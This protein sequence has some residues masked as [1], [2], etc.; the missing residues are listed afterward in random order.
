[1]DIH[2]RAKRW[3]FLVLAAVACAGCDEPVSDPM[4]RPVQAVKIGDVSQ[5]TGRPFPGKAKAVE[6]ANLSF[7]VSGPLIQLPAKVGAVVEK[8]DLL[9]QIDRRD[10]EVQL[11]AEKANLTRAQANLKAMESGD[12]PEEI[13]Q[14]KAQVEKITAAHTLADTEYARARKLLPSG[15]LSQSEHDKWQE[16]FLR[17]GAELRQ[18]QES[19][20]IGIAGARQEDIDAKKSEIHS[21][22]AAVEAAEDRLDDTEL[23]APFDGIVVATYVENFETVKEQ[24]LIV[25]LLDISK[26]EMIIDVPETV[27]AL[28][29]YADKIVC[30]FRPL[31]DREV[32][33]PA[34]IVEIGS[35][36]SQTTRTYPITLRMN[37]PDDPDLP[38][39]TLIRPGMAGTARA[40]AA[41]PG[42]A[43]KEGYDVPETAVVSTEGRRY[44]WVVG[45]G[46]IVA[47]QDVTIGDTATDGLYLIE[48]V[49]KGQWVVTAGAHYLEEGQ[50]VHVMGEAK[51]EVPE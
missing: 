29:E 34:E 2:K 14:L 42:M 30:T 18:A 44:V 32:S 50:K 17:T 46:G 3:T 21:L 8:D 5:L 4:I 47:S 39:G 43:D 7:R 41:R 19:L 25:R 11:R 10:Y 16:E 31:P 1:M 38:E 35:E 9:A 15:N 22:E 27:I 36:A 23:K 40:T 6:E 45:E 49:K 51:S 48:G 12:R 20:E 28:A 13:E 33:V 37:Q 26:I 24:E